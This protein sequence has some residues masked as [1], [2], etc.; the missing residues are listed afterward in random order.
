MIDRIGFALISALIT[1]TVIAFAKSKAT[2]LKT[3]MSIAALS[4][5]P[6]NTT[7]RQST[8]SRYG[9]D[10]LDL[11]SV[12]ISVADPLVVQT[13]E[14]IRNTFNAQRKAACPSLELYSTRGA[15]QY[16]KKAVQSNGTIL[17][18]M[19]IVFGDEA[20]FARVAL[21]P[22]NNGAKFQMILSVPGPCEGGVQ[23]QLA[24]SALGTLTMVIHPM[25]A[26]SG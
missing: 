22:D 23:E 9:Q 16:A 7:S 12:I 8:P 17:Y 4:G 10:S 6:Q 15:I 25:L 3:G 14:T 19:E 2:D 20:I 11:E 21:L 18:T 1:I 13:G 24:I 5:W 26:I